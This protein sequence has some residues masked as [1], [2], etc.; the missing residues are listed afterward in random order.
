MGGKTY[1][2]NEDSCSDKKVMITRGGGGGG[3]QPLSNA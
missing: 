1:I 3:A 2:Y